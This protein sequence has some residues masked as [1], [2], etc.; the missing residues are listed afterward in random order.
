MT[1]VQYSFEFNERKTSQ[2][3]QVETAHQQREI[4]NAIL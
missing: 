4:V 3:I 2:N 1:T